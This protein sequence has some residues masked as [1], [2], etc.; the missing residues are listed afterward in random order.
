V[1][2]CR[3]GT[4]YL[5]LRRLPQPLDLFGKFQVAGH[6]LQGSNTSVDERLVLLGGRAV[7]EAVDAVLDAVS[8]LA[9]VLD[10]QA[11]HG[12]MVFGLRGELIVDGA[13]NHT[14]L[15]CE[16]RDV[17]LDAL[18]QLVLLLGQRAQLG[19]DRFDEPAHK[20][21]LHCF[22]LSSMNYELIC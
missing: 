17:V 11:R 15:L 7:H 3:P 9:Q 20:G 18:A 2:G 19:D 21:G 14:E 8:Q 5:C 16:E 4:G 13:H 6:V 22:L 10:R 1:E 12:P